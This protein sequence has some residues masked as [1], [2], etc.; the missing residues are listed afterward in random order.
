M[1]WFPR[2]LYNIFRLFGKEEGPFLRE[3]SLFFQSAINPFVYFF[4]RTDFKCA[5]VRL[6]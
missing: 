2:G 1:C 5:L 4:Y 6:L 3:L